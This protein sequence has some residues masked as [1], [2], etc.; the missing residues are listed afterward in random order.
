M[1]LIKTNIGAYDHGNVRITSLPFVALSQVMR[2]TS[3]YEFQLG[4]DG[5]TCSWATN[6]V[7][8]DEVNM[9]KMS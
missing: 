2:T 3:S 4:P 5:A 7:P 6:T 8:I 1:Q 9:R